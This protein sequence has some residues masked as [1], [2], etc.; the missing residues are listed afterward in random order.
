MSD[1]KHYARAA[2]DPRVITEVAAQL[3]KT[4]D[5]RG[6][7]TA[8]DGERST[9]AHARTILGIFGTGQNEAAVMGYLRRA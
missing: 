2:A 6:E 1:I 4:W 9:E 3:A 8:P 7:F 5:R